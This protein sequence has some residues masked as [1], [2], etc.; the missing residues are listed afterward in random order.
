MKLF[1]PFKIGTLELKNR[2][3]RS[4]TYEKMADVDGFVT[5]QMIDLYKNLAIGGVGLIITGN[6]LV[7]LSGYSAPQ[8]ICIHNDFYIEG[9][10]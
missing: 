2:I 1:E 4:A 10:K 6:A 3:V 5:E 7:H 9:L 8:Q